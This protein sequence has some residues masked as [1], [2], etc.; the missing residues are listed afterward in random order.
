MLG[1]AP[2]AAQTTA[3]GPATPS[4]FTL[5]P[6]IGYTTYTDIAKLP[7]RDDGSIPDFPFTGSV[8]AKLDAQL[9]FGLSAE[10]Q[11]LTSRWGAFGDFSRGGGDGDLTVRV[12]FSDP[13]FGTE[14][15]SQSVDAT[16][17]QWRASAGVTRRFSLGT[18]S[19]ATLWLGALYA[20]TH[21]EVEDAEA[22]APDLDESSPGAIIGGALDLPLTPRAVIRLQL[23]DSFMRVKGSTFARDLNSSAG[24]EGIIVES[25]DKFM[26]AFNFGVGLVLRL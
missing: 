1:A 13:D 14:C 24:G 10:F 4:V 21:F 2:L 9:T 5:T 6:H 22:G 17:S 20:K 7:I 11:P 8:A 15:G 12:C 26:N 25:D 19:T 18:A 16:G 23:R 3:A